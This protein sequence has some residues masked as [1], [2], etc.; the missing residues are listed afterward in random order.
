[1]GW[2]EE[3]LSRETAFTYVRK[4]EGKG[5]FFKIIFNYVY[6]GVRV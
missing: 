5:I 4:R 1:M 6:A 2:K 3:G